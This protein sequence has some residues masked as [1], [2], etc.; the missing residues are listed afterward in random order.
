[1]K[2][3]FLSTLISVGFAAN[4]QIGTGASTKIGGE[5]SRWTFGGGVSFGLSGGSGG[6]GTAIGISPRVGY[7]VSNNFEVGV[8]AGINW[9]NN[10]YYSSTMFG[11]GPFAN[12][13]FSRNFYVSGLYQHYFYNL[14]DKY[15][16]L[17][18]NDQ[19]PA[20]YLG[21]GYMQKIGERAYMQ[22]G[23]MYNVLYDKND[24]VF[25]G[26]FVPSVGIVYGL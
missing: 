11:V 22:I 15:Y 26:G 10:K 24:S 4:A 13:Y 6:T 8:S 2:K 14:K 3:L 9:S 21:G 17:K 5:N 18:Y 1:M 20:L 7:L 19:E 16:D 23:A 12:Y 25:G